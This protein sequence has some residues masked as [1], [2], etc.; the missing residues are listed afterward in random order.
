MQPWLYNVCR[1]DFQLR[2]DEE[3]N[4]YILEVAIPR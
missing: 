2:E 4:R 3:N 1:Y